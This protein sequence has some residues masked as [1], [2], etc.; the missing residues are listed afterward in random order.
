MKKFEIRGFN[1]CESLLRHTPE[2]LRAFIRRMKKLQMNTIIIHYDYGW[3][4]YKEII[5]EECERAG[6]EIILM[7]FGP[8]TFLSYVD[9][10]KGWFAKKADGTLFNETLECETYP[11]PHEKGVLEAYEFGAKKWLM[12][13]PQQI[14][15]VHM[16]AADGLNFCRCN[17]CKN[18]PEQEKW[19]PF[20]DV[21]V[22]AVLETRPELK[23]ETDVYV[24]RYSIPER[25][26]SF[27]EMSNIMFDTFYRH[28]AFPIGSNADICNAE[29]LN[30]AAS[31]NE[32][33]TAKTP[34]EYYS[35]KL[36]QWAGAF[37]G[38]VYI[39]ENA[40]K[41]SYFGTFQYGTA[42]YLKD[43][44]LYSKLGVSGVCYE[45]YEPGYYSFS[46]MFELLAR[47]MNGEEIDYEESEIEKA[48]S[49]SSM[50]LFC[51]DADFPLEKYISDPFELKNA[52][53]YRRFWLEHTPSLY[54]EYVDFAFENK[55]KLDPVF[56]GFAIADWGVRWNKLKFRGLSDGAYKMLHTNKL[57]D[58]MEAIP[59]NEDPIAVC[60]E[61]IYEL[62]K[63]AEKI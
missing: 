8:R 59:D 31:T 27:S 1:P 21:F 30:Y 26:N 63:K 20:V 6:I 58:F 60:T 14:R 45:A 62:V 41:Q 61:L 4:R 3:K 5:I 9:Y 42:S 25:I 39:H 34:N 19:Q 28:T 35:Q 36:Y 15:H 33:I 38:K 54:G 57:W 44:E 52:M 24:K 49:R 22:K 16:R 32:I 50:N 51:N 37:P 29:L 46:K 11:C 56:I 2:Q 17:I 40:M 47:A 48:V 23:F 7:T 12:S 18:M 13:L 43:L 10:D 53:L 55:D